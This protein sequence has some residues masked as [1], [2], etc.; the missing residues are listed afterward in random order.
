MLR[1]T[2]AM[3]KQ[4]FADNGLS[5]CRFALTPNESGQCCGL[6]AIAVNEGQ[7]PDNYPKGYSYSYCIGFVHA[8]DDVEEF[9]VENARM[10]RGGKALE[11]YNAGF[12]DGLACAVACGLNGSGL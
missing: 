2:P 1:A 4:A 7:S 8:W 11:H 9:E 3:V 5:P 10:W 12:A 6:G